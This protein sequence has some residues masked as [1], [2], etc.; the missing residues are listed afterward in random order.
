MNRSILYT[1]QTWE[2][3]HYHNVPGDPGGGTKFGISQRA[4]P[5]LDIENLTLAE[6]H[7]IYVRDYWNKIHADSVHDPKIAWKLFDISVN[8]GV[9]GAVTV[10][11]RAI[12]KIDTPLDESIALLN[13]MDSRVAMDRIMLAQIRRY[14]TIVSSNATKI[15]FLLGWL[16]RALDDGSSLQIS[17]GTESSPPTT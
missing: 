3:E 6:A 5:K 13:N 7:E 17:P 15:K 8:S 9:L 1:I 2:G 10:V 14:V 11:A 4:Y 16:R 12:A